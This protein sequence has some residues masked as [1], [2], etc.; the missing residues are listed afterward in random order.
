MTT[1]DYQAPSTKHHSPICEESAS[2]AVWQLAEID[3]RRAAQISQR[4]GLPDLIAKLLVERGIVDE[5]VETFLNPKLKTSLPDPLMF[6][7][8]KAGA[9]RLTAAI[10]AGEKVAIFGDYDVDGATSSALLTLYLRQV[11]IEPIV[12]IPDRMKEGYGPNKEAF[13]TLKAQDASLV[14]TVDC[15]T[16]A[17]EPLE[18][19]REIGL[20]VMV[21]DHHQAEAKLPDA[22]A[23]INPNRLDESGACRQLAAVGVCYLL[24]IAVQ[25]LLKEKG[26]FLGTKSESVDEPAMSVRE[27]NSPCESQKAFTGQNKKEPDLLSLLDIVAIGTVCDVVPLTEL[28]RSLVAQGLKIM[29]SNGHIGVQALREVASVMDKPLNASHLGFALG[30]RINAGGRVGRAGA[31]VELLTTNDPLKAKQIADE[32]DKYNAERR[33]IESQMAEE[34]MAQAEIEVEKTGEQGSVIVVANQAWHQGIIGI[35]ASRL[36]EKFH[37]PAIVISTEQETIGKGSCRS[38][39]GF[40]MGAAVISAQSE[41]L[42][43]KGGGHAMAAG[44]SIDPVRIDEFKSF[45]NSRYQA[46]ECHSY[47]AEHTVDAVIRASGI[48]LE[49][50]HMLEKLAP[51]GSGNPEPLMMISKARL[52]KSSVVG[53]GHVK[54]LWVDETLKHPA[55]SGITFR[56]EDTQLG[57]QL[58]RHPK[59]VWDILTTLEINH[60][61]G[62]QRINLMVKDATLK[63]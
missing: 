34:A 57:Q 1:A 26:L 45:M 30:P 10:I 59:R 46:A 35:V 19:A 37:R 48:N 28:N 29:N 13:D 24:L 39:A 61:Q 15:G 11:G 4:H 43:M 54:T 2:G 6:Q 38:V 31:G 55:L 36:K 60:W 63:A 44:F 50:L 9:E 49:L 14:I 32:L 41:G 62:Q 23:V 56:A 52:L 18:H 5:Q 3:E 25:R 20:E 8:M 33:A 47:Q 42:L 16:L 12:Y 7:D 53:Q 51:F 40:D 22:V 21:V 27:A 17:F 58:L